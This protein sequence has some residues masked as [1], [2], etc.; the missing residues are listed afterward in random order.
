MMINK[1]YSSLE[2]SLIVSEYNCLRDEIQARLS[3]LFKLHQG[4][5]LG[6]LIYSTT[7]YVPN[8]LSVLDKGQTYIA[9]VTLLYF[10]FIFIIP[11]ITFVVELIC[12]SE[13]DAI[14]RAGIYIKEHIERVH[15]K[16]T[17][18]GWEDW[19]IRQDK[20]KRRRTSDNLI[21]KT[22]RL[23]IIPLYCICSS[24]VCTAGFSVYFKITFFYS[25]LLEISILFIYFC[26]YFLLIKKL[27]KAQRE[28]FITPD[29]N[30]MV[31]DLDGC[32]LDDDKEISEMNREAISYI[33]GKGVHVIIA[34]G[35]G[36]LS[37]KGICQK[38][39]LEGSHV[40]CH[41][42]NIYNV[43][44]DQEEQLKCCLTDKDLKEIIKELNKSD[45]K[46]VAF[47]I[48][49]Y[50][51]MNRDIEYVRQS[52]IERL[53][54]PE[55]NLDIV[56]QIKEIDSFEWKEKISKVLCYLSTPQNGIIKE[57]PKSTIK[58]IS[59]K[60]SKK[61]QVVPSTKKT[62]EI[63]HKNAKKRMRL[64]KFLII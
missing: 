54:V 26:F 16:S 7:F 31:L 19:L 50:Y 38:I 48:K 44:D 60:L 4:L 10:L 35:R 47:G 36:A 1:N 22:R 21:I 11:I 57:I 63:I 27:N 32:L 18:K 20:V 6:T 12:T 62:L 2:K 29:Y 56:H 33:T 5:L 34:T 52:L 15:R 14:F 59:K 45:I 30:V 42:A 28:E 58:E 46:W 17:F 13:Q 39:N 37:I 49:R 41:G 40:T 55:N 9:T 53:D 61:Y 64:L 51:C 23:L 24:I 25:L 8:L 43:S 3:R